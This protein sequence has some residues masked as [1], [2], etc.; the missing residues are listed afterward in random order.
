MLD[1]VGRLTD[2]IDNKLITSITTA[3]TSKAFDSVEHCRLL[4]KLGWYGIERHWFEDWM[5][6]RRQRVGPDSTT[7]RPIT[8]GIVQGSVLGPVLFLIFTN[9]LPE[10]LDKQGTDI[11]M[12]ADDVQFLHSGN[13]SNVIE[14]QNR[15]ENTLLKA[16]TWF[17][18]NRLKINPTKTDVI[19]VR[20]R[21]RRA[22][23]KMKIQF[24]DAYIPLSE[25]TK[26][27]GIVLDE[28]LS[29]KAH[30]S[31]IIQRC[32]ATLS[33]L[34][35][36]T[37]RLS[38][39][40]KK[41]IVESLIFPHIHYCLTVW[42]SCNAGQ[43]HRIQKVVNHCA[44]V[45]HCAR[46]RDHVSPMLRELKWL[47]VGD[48]LAVRDVAAVYRAL[49]QAHAPA[50]L[51]DMFTLVS[52]VSSAETRQ[53]AEEHLR[54]PQVR[55]ELARRSFRY[56]AAVTWNQAPAA[57]RCAPSVAALTAR[58]TKWQLS[59]FSARQ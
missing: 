46:R 43:R 4:E 15:V 6:G 3:D 55:T 36:F 29:W 9:D 30:V 10:H 19:V 7:D 11:V 45:V 50:A 23:I 54:P 16:Q 12:Y 5:R 48:L 57:V 38:Y 25:T 47:N 53:R 37:H 32:Y 27:L 58:A 34:T 59:K 28:N 49:R 52:D 14:L 42:G 2:N 44:R 18:Q 40:V 39:E 24:G 20:S 35:K 17:N 56:R 21:Q 31:A 13:P 22:E 26:I 1:V 51:R 8:H 33:G 41:M